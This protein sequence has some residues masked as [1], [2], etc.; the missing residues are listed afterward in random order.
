MRHALA[1]LERRGYGDLAEVLGL[2]RTEERNHH[3]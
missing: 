2:D 3:A 1:Y